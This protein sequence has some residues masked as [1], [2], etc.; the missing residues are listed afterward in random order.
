ML[1]QE[2]GKALGD[3][4]Q[5]PKKFLYSTI[6]NGMKKIGLDGVEYKT[7]GNVSAEI[8]ND[9]DLSIP[10]ESLAKKWNLPTPYYSDE[11]WNT[12]KQ[13]VSQIPG[14][15]FRAGLNEFHV[16]FELVDEKGSK[17]PMYKDG[18]PIP[19]S[20]GVAQVDF[21]VGSDTWMKDVLSGK[22]EGSNFKAAF[23]NVLLG[24]I[25]STIDRDF[26]EPVQTEEFPQG[27]FE[28]HKYVLN[29][30]SGVEKVVTRMANPDPKNKR[31]KNPQRI[32]VKRENY[33]EDQNEMA[34]WLFGSGYTWEKINSFEKAMEAFLN[35]KYYNK[36]YG[37]YREDIISKVKETLSP[38][39]AEMLQSGQYA[40][41]FKESM[42]S[43]GRES[44]GRFSGKNEFTPV[45]FLNLLKKL[46]EE[47]NNI[48]KEKFTIDL[49]NDPSVDM[50]EKMDASFI[51]FGINKDGKFFMESNYSGEVTADNAEEK[52]GFR[53]ESIESF[54]FLYENK[55]LQ[56]ALQQIYKTYGPIRFDSEMLFISEPTRKD[57][58]TKD[59][60]FASTRY[61]KEKLG[62][63]GG[64]VVF[65]CSKWSEEKN[66]W[67]RPEPSVSAEIISNFKKLTSNLEKEWKIYSN[68]EDMRL[69]G[70]IT[71][72]LGSLAD[73]IQPENFEKTVAIVKSRKE[74][75]EKIILLDKI[76]SLRTQLQ[77]AL[78]KFADRA[79]SK[80]GDKDSNVEGVVLRIK[81]K[82]G[83]V[84]EVKGTSEKFAER[85]KI[86]WQDRKN[87]E[88]AKD[89]F[90]TSIKKEI[91][92]LPA[93]NDKTILANIEEYMKTNSLEE[94]IKLIIPNYEEVLA[95]SQKNLN[96][97]LAKAREEVKA[98]KSSIESKKDVLDKD[99]ERKSFD[100]IKN[101]SILL[102]DYEIIGTSRNSKNKKHLLILQKY[103][104]PKLQPA[105]VKP[106]EEPQRPAA[107]NAGGTRVIVWNGR[108]QPW[109][110][111]H[112]AM[113]ELGKQKLASLNA[114]K[115]VIMI[116]KG[117]KSSKDL[118][119][120]PLNEKEQLDLITSIY[121]S[122][123]QVQVLDQ[124]PL[125]AFSVLD[126]CSKN[127]FIAV[128]WLAGKDD[129]AEGYEDIIRR[130]DVDKFMKDHDFMPFVIDETTRKPLIEFI[131]T[132]RVFSGTKSR[133]LVK[134]PE[135]TFEKWVTEIAPTNI[136]SEAKKEYEN[137][138][139]IM[140]ERIPDGLN[141][142][143]I[144][145][146]NETIVK[147]KN[148]FCL[149]SKK[150][151]RNLGCY[152]SKN[153]A[154]KREKQVQYFKHLKEMSSIAGGGI[155]MAPANPI[156]TKEE[157]K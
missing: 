75:N 24:S 49:L 156:D 108:A 67:V 23:R 102:N 141:E 92:G 10:V 93:N 101:L 53:A 46:S 95:N 41:L 85:A 44:I 39:Q 2:G 89:E 69:P 109:H 42:L 21:F 113:I 117:G 153:G 32:S 64:S 55:K 121:G 61:R 147:R 1:L 142:I 25:I 100:Y 16:P 99:S 12:I 106:K 124:F 29:F 104:G 140:K 110:K 73:A 18:K 34:S 154:K 139:N 3:S 119:E 84:F 76:N 125:N 103:F 5:I 144:S 127:K 126:I 35:N 26:T 105:V 33:I 70:K 134:Q 7:V 122:D 115:I 63:F 43:E 59:V 28:E 68:D 79:S 40:E 78:N 145:V 148:K 71:V 116:V 56:S 135:M 82:D 123:S 87:S 6:E 118:S 17:Q 57:A 152:R 36:K 112:A 19:N 130:F 50:V 114:E 80:L 62:K 133:T 150:T 58:K 83:E 47:S 66:N 9:V 77:D 13:K 14:A 30:K 51:H 131:K 20:I 107:S 128:G 111:G 52:F 98:I 60:V 54:N 15:K 37:K 120:N 138:Y 48:G 27:E 136:S 129:R 157:T 97:A 65:K 38:E 155:V 146:L 94:A 137:V 22:P 91:L 88:I 11:F 96:I 143:I 74:S 4:S 72:E 86:I 149:I 151:G 45:Q 8:S 81:A 90:L 31:Q 132:E